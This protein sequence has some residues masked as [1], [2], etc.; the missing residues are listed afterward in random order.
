MCAITLIKIIGDLTVYSSEND[1]R[2]KQMHEAILHNAPPEGKHWNDLGANNLNIRVAVVLFADMLSKQLGKPADSIYRI[3]DLICTFVALVLIYYLL[4]SSFSSTFALTGVLL[5]CTLLPLTMLDHHFHPW[6][7]PMLILWPAMIWA[8]AKNRLLA[9]GCFY[10]LAIVIKLDSIL[11]AGMVWFAAVR[12][13]N[14]IRPTFTTAAIGAVGALTLGVLLF[15]LPGGQEPIDLVTQLQRNFDVAKSHGITYPPLLAHGLLLVLSLF[16][17]QS[18]S[19]L[20]KRFWLFGLCMLVPHLLLTNFVEVRAQ[21]GTILCML[22]LAVQG[23]FAVN[24]N[25]PL[26]R[27]DPFLIKR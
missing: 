20:M 1:G 3:I 19:E 8:A 11:A 24:G 12:W 17:W 25:A 22:P 13:D 2:R 7:R 18:A 15:L 26:A 27:T 4:K 6:D 14:W 10:V 16:G 21:I 5:F 23:L 9:F